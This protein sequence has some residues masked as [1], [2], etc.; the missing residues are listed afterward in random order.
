MFMTLVTGCV[1]IAYI[2]LILIGMFIYCFSKNIKNKMKIVYLLKD[3]S[4]TICILNIIFSFYFFA[5][6]DWVIDNY[7]A[8]YISVSIVSLFCY[9]IFSYM[10]GKTSEKAYAIL[11]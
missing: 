10:R 2:V 9:V 6:N 8:Y 11:Q 4:G 3:F 1:A 7:L 5:Y